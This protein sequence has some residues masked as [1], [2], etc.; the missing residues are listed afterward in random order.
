MP[1]TLKQDLEAVDKAIES[2][3]TDRG[4]LRHDIWETLGIETEHA[5][6]FL[7]Y[8]LANA[9]LMDRK[10]RDYGPRNISKG[11]TFGC[12]LRASDKFERLFTLYQS[13]RR[14]RAINES[15]EDT[16]RDISNY[17]IIALMVEGGKWSNE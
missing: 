16:F 5:K 4:S 3:P 10:Q 9:R 13:G 8:S 14:K 12:V 6:E 1:I 15:I 2:R 7:R 17:M 11:G